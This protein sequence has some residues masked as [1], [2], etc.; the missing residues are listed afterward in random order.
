MTSERQILDPLPQVMK[1]YPTASP[2]PP[3]ARRRRPG[4]W[5]ALRFFWKV[6]Y[7]FRSGTGVYGENTL[8]VAV[9]GKTKGELARIFLRAVTR[10]VMRW[11]YYVFS[12]VVAA[13]GVALSVYFDDPDLLLVTLGV[14]F[15]T[16][17]LAWVFS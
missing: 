3:P 5:Q 7:L 16:L 12:G 9:T 10:F 4:F 11:R 8:I 15:F 14:T 13:G 6:F 1:P 17:T 2:S